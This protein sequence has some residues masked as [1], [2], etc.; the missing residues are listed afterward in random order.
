MSHK[1]VVIPCSQCGNPRNAYVIRG[2]P[3]IKVCA[4]CS[5]TNHRTSRNRLPN[6]RDFLEALYWNQKLS[7]PQIGRMFKVSPSTVRAKLR[8]LGIKIRSH[9]E[10]QSLRSG[11]NSP[12]YKNG[13]TH[14]RPDGYILILKP[15]HPRAVQGYVKEHV[16][17]WEQV[18]GK[19]LPEGWHVHHLNGVKSDNRPSN[20]LGLPNKKHMALLSA[21]A[22]RI[23][24]LESLLKQ[25][26]QLL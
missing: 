19:P 18:H 7:L 11:V 8:D 2:E 16:L 17:V 10:A 3:V 25:Q 26:G 9:Q 23:Q 6:E 5:N 15:E 22:K 24:E 1:F 21:M 13:R 14:T 4:K 20:L 12:S